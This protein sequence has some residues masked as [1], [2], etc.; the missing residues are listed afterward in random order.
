MGRPN[1][2]SPSDEDY[3]EEILMV[4]IQMTQ[5]LATTGFS[6]EVTGD[7]RDCTQQIAEAKR[8]LGAFVMAVAASLGSETANLAA[9][10]WLEIAEHTTLTQRGAC[11]NWRQITIAAA[12]RMA[13]S[14][15]P[16]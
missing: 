13:S 2:A 4:S 7:S 14:L 5:P 12:S 16:A 6:F 9:E 3:E 1:A 15:H 8:E 11:R 10:Y